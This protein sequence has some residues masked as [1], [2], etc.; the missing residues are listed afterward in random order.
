MKNH[1]NARVTRSYNRLI[2]R[3]GANTVDCAHFCPTDPCPIC[4]RLD[5]EFVQIKK[6]LA[7]C[8]KALGYRVSAASK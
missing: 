2:R 8:D 1:Q 7:V 4:I 5:K 3:L 6:S